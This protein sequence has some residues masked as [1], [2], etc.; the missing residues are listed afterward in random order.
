[1]VSLEWS[2]LPAQEVMNGPW[3]VA[4]DFHGTGRDD[5]AFL[6]EDASLTVE[7][8]STIG[9]SKLVL[10][11]RI[12]IVT[13]QTG[14]GTLCAYFV[15]PGNQ[16]VDG[17]IAGDFNGDGR[18]DLAVTGHADS[19]YYPLQL[20]LP[21]TVLEDTTVTLDGATGRLIPLRPGTRSQ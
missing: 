10:K 19:V 9:N 5:I 11:S 13:A 18:M 12:G 1:M 16:S 4:A 20:P 17:M 2:G 14:M 7:D 6:S 3:L 8:P 21:S 15:D